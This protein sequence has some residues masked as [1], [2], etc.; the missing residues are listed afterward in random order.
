MPRYKDEEYRVPN[1]Q[2]FI[3]KGTDGQSG[4]CDKWGVVNAL[5]KEGEKLR[6]M[7]CLWDR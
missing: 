5:K 3:E 7:N 1:M 6:C 4:Q 2:A